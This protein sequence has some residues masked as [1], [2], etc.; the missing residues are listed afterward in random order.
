MKLHKKQLSDEDIA[1]MADENQ[2]LPISECHRGR[3]YAATRD[4]NKRAVRFYDSSKGVAD[5]SAM[6]KFRDDIERNTLC[7]NTIH[8]KID[9][10]G[11]TEEEA[12]AALVALVENL[13]ARQTGSGAATVITGASGI[14][15]E[16]FQQW[17]TESRISNRIVSVQPLNRGSFKIMVRRAKN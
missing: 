12:W 17:A 6:R 8:N 14:L 11:K 2:P 9:F 5:I 15:K 16:K 4:P 3:G 1:R 10:H 7:G 13:A